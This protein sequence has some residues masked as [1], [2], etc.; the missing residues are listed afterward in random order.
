MEVIHAVRVSCSGITNGFRSPLSQSVHDTLPFPTP[1]HLIG[2]LGAAMGVSR[3]DIEPLYYSFKV[4]VVGT[5]SATYQDL[6][7]IL[8]YK[9]SKQ[10]SSLLI[11]ENLFN[12]DFQIWYIPTGNLGSDIVMKSLKNPK[13]ALSLGRDDEIIRMNEVS[14]VELTNVENPLL[15]NTVV[16]FSL[17]PATD[18]VSGEE[19]FMAPLVSVPLPRTFKIDMKLRRTPTDFVNYT[20]IEGYAI[21]TTRKGCYSDGSEQ[22]FAL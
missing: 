16:P 19:K 18:K 15:K 13:F 17:D 9:G 1:T 4:G 11:R 14:E 22:F 8:K 3:R 10:F 6:T 5:H 20:F 12:T 7:R 21:E 2:M